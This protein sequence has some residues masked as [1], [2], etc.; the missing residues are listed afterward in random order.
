MALAVNLNLDDVYEINPLSEDLR[1]STFITDL[2][3]GTSIPLQVEISSEPHA[4]LSSVFNLAFG[5][6]NARGQIDDIAEL[7]HED[8][9]KVFSSILFAGVTY[10]T[11]HRDH[12]LGIDGSND[13][14][15]YL[16][17][18][19]LQ[20][21]FTYLDNLFEMYGLKYYVRINRFGKNQ[22]DNPFD[23][24]DVIPSPVGIKRREK[25]QDAMYN[26]F[27]FKLK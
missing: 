27:I 6:L 23:F 13:L 21:N 26:Y 22:Y 24:N 15:A 5:P 1:V 12:Y 8:Y 3:D 10:L 20:R 4:L 7:A 14:R 18:R 2:Q 16:Y 25:W 17:F 9:S 19:H 11:D